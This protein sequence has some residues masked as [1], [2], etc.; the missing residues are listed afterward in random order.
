MSDQQKQVEDENLDQVSGGAISFPPPPMPIRPPGQP[1]THP[2]KGVP[3][4][5]K[6]GPKAV[7]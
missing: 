6:P 5:I 3:E 2:G 1:P 7:D 4:P